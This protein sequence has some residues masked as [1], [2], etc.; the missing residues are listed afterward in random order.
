[1]AG[2][3]ITAFSPAL[4]QYQNFGVSHAIYV[5][6][7]SL[8]A[9]LWWLKFAVNDIGVPADAKNCV[10]VDMKHKQFNVTDFHGPVILLMLVI[11]WT[12]AVD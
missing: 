2:K 11:W 12:V 9:T 4:S 10:K 1:M 7:Y 6:F 5:Q 3:K 8:S